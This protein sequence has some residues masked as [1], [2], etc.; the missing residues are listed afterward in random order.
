[1]ASC[2]V[3]CRELSVDEL[4]DVALE[5]DFDLNVGLH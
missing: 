4:V 2:L 3:C 5:T 1:M